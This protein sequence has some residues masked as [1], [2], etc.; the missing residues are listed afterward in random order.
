M[1]H[2]TLSPSRATCSAWWQETW[3]S[4][5][6]ATPHT[7]GAP[8]ASRRTCQQ[9]TL[10][11]CGSNRQ[12]ATHSH[13]WSLIRSCRTAIAGDVQAASHLLLFACRCKPPAVLHAC[14]HVSYGCMLIPCW[15][16]RV[17]CLSR[18]DL[19]LPIQVQC[20]PCCLRAVA[21]VCNCH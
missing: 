9:R 19:A 1:L 14:M 8:S 5:R 11:R 17:C 18:Q 7:R 10:T 20:G 4:G 16:C 3:P 21:R 2:R 15:W 12:T 13:H 6:T